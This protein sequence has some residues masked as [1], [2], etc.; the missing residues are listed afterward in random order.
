LPLGKDSA[1]LH[2]EEKKKGS[3]SKAPSRSQ[4][5]KATARSV[6]TEGGD[7]EGKADGMSQGGSKAWQRPPQHAPEDGMLLENVLERWV[8]LKEMIHCMLVSYSLPSK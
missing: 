1:S 3:G 6:A 4:T 7:G 8:E 2:A 5:P